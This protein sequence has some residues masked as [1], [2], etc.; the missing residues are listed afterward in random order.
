MRQY[1]DYE[2][3]VRSQLWHYK[4]LRATIEILQ[5]KVKQIETEA[6]TIRG[7]SVGEMS[8]TP[9]ST[10]PSDPTMRKGLKCAEMEKQIAIYRVGIE[11]I[12]SRLR[13]IDIA[14]STLDEDGQDLVRKN[15]IERI[16]FSVICQEKF[17]SERTAKRKLALFIK[18]LSGVMYDK[19]MCDKGLPFVF[20]S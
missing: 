9:R 18:C 15:L 16:P 12:Q 4:D 13:Q 11:R 2:V 3:I 10:A 17:I 8:D 6:D 5:E 1:N 14:L 7:L 20:V 19:A